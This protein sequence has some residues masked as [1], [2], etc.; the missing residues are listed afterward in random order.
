MAPKNIWGPSCKESEIRYI[1]EKLTTTGK[2][3][4]DESEMKKLK[5]IC[6]LSDKY[7]NCAYYAL[8]T[9]LRKEHSEIRYS[10]LLIMN[11]LFCRSSAF[12]TKLESDFEEFLELVEGTN[13][14]KPLPLPVP[15]SKE[16]KIKGLEF[17]KNWATKF[18]EK[19]IRLPLAVN[20]LKKCKKVDF[21]DMEA[22]NVA[23]RERQH[24]EQER[25]DRLTNEKIAKIKTEMQEISEE[26]SIVAIQMENCFKLLIPHSSNELF[27]ADDFEEK[28]S[29]PKDNCAE[30]SYMNCSDA[31]TPENVASSTAGER[32]RDHGVYDMK[33]TLTIEMNKDSEVDINDDT[34][35][36]IENLKDFEKQINTR[37]YPMVT[38]WLK[39]LSKGN[40]CSD[41]LKKAID[42]KLLL[43]SSLEKYKELKIKPSKIIMDSDEDGDF[44]EVKEKEGYETRVQV[45]RVPG[46][47]SVSASTS[48]CES[49]L[50][51]KLGPKDD[52]ED[53]TSAA[54]TIQK[55]LKC[56]QSSPVF[57]DMN[58]L[59]S[60]SADKKEVKSHKAELLGKAPVLPYDID[61]YH[62]EDEKPLIPERVKF[63][64]LHKFWEAKDEDT[65]EN[66]ALIEVQ[67]AS[68]RTR[69]IDFSGKFEPVKWMCR[70][71][72][73]N[74]KLCP[75]K[76]RYKCPFHGKI[77]PRDVLGNPSGDPGS[78]PGPSTAP[79]TSAVPDWQDPSLL[80]D[81]E[82][83]TG[84]DLKVPDK[85]SKKGGKRKK[86]GLTNIKHINNTVRERLSKKIGKRYHHYA[87]KMD[88]TEKK[89]FDD[90]FGDQWNYY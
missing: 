79:S 63:D 82:A 77:I 54:S 29:E 27:S 59:E 24:Q 48:N 70:A 46:I 65:E 22:R 85:R 2:K 57:V 90:K 84:I 69:K 71:P 78:I 72:L 42:L 83:A 41:I 61:L 60:T 66:E 30:D 47:S 74:S 45:P 55:R 81:I 17:I 12:R 3:T 19:Y 73:P 87:K 13:P 39:I 80:R 4:L 64:S 16:L 40:N 14:E 6:K 68:L 44:E 76:D 89:R 51:W 23:E 56:I 43:E 9:Q 18:G 53:P 21:N 28:H 50:L 38:R 35:P 1:I 34:S 75:R 11:E 36:I 5:T 67:I 58:Q 49:S 37:Y 32:L 31:L 88:E 52:I 26:M 15:V 20:Y 7:V 86:D 62:W 33:K 10:T 25:V 8:M